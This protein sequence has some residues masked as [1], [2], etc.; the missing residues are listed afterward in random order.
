MDCVAHLNAEQILGKTD[1]DLFPKE[2]AEKFY[3]NDME[4]VA[5]G[6]PVELE[7]VVPLADGPHTYITLKF[8]VRDLDGTLYAICGIATDITERKRSEQQHAALQQQIIQR[9]G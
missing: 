7:E 8:P 2:L 4:V 9:K 3:A 5:G 1:F 6:V